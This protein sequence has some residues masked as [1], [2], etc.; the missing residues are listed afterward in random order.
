MN[1]TLDK[2]MKQSNEVI[3]VAPVPVTTNTNEQAVIPKNIVPD[4]K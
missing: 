2:T 4:L 3:S 1:E